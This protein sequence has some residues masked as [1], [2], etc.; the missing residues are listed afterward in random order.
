VP[1]GPLPISTQTLALMK[2]IEATGVALGALDSALEGHPLIDGW[3]YRA[4]L[5]E[6]VVLGAIDGLAVSRDRLFTNLTGLPTRLHRDAGAELRV[7]GLFQALEGTAPI[8]SEIES[9][10]A[11][12][13]SQTSEATLL[14]AARGVRRWSEGG[15][16]RASAAYLAVP[17]YLAASGLTR[18]PLPCLTAARMERRRSATCD[19][20]T[21]SFLNALRLAAVQGRQDLR[22]L[23]ESWRRLQRRIGRR[24]RHSRLAAVGSLALC[25]PVLTPAYVS[26]LFGMSVRGASLIL[27]ELA[28][29]RLISE[30]TMRRSW[31][32]YVPADL[33]GPTDLGTI[34]RR[35]A[36]RRDETA[37]PSK[38][39]TAIPPIED[40]PLGQPSGALS[41]DEKA[42]FSAL[43]TDTD[44]AL[45][46]ARQ[47]L[48]QASDIRGGARRRNPG[49]SRNE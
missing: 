24:R 10:L 12:L 48:S 41:L 2:L 1:F 35:P 34:A 5:D 37:G 15:A 4:K 27:G 45:R 29:M 28:D 30:V 13:R 22:A 16:I 42:D 23:T 31:T 40:R 6:A 43:M 49:D 21:I 7:A 20:W 25:V 33:E 11:D 19:E 17:R 8:G 32:A 14:A 36:T 39:A 46:R 38:T 26:R 47:V 3:L 18:R 9:V 44:R